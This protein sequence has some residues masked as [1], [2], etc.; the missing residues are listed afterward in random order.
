MCLIRY[1]ILKEAF[2]RFFPK[3]L[4]SVT[5]LF[6]VFSAFAQ[7]E[8]G[9]V[10][11]GLSKQ[12]VIKR[13][14]SLQAQYQ[15]V[16]SLRL[17]S[18]PSTEILLH[19]KGDEGI[20]FQKYE[21]DNET[22]EKTKK[23]VAESAKQGYQKYLDEFTEQLQKKVLIPLC[24]ENKSK[25]L[26]PLKALE[27]KK[28]A[29]IKVK[30]VL[31]LQKELKPQDEKLAFGIDTHIMAFDAEIADGM[32]DFLKITGF[33][34]LPARMHVT[35]KGLEMIMGPNALKNY[36]TSDEGVLDKSVERLWEDLKGFYRS[37]DRSDLGSRLEE[38][39]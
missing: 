26:M 19:I 11:S 3:G 34:C 38:L 30:P 25:F 6:L 7:D 31:M 33:E 39:R 22:V 21:V 32:Q 14:A 27:K 5:I 9:H 16:K 28:T 24:D 20:P 2:Y 35:K 4:L 37:R 18:P 36:D 1:S 17:K 23:M 13:G 10:L 12:D 8:T 15:I 29:N